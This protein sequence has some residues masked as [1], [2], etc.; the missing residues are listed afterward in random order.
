MTGDDED[1]DYEMAPDYDEDDVRLYP[2][3]AHRWVK[4]AKTFP[5]HFFL[6]QT[7]DERLEL[8]REYAGAMQNLTD[9]QKVDF[10]L[11]KAAK[12]LQGRG[13]GPTAVLTRDR[14]WGISLAQRCD[15]EGVRV[16]HDRALM[17]EYL[18]PQ[19]RSKDIC[20]ILFP[21]S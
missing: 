18:D 21:E 4:S 20:Q 16:L 14:R 6:E 11:A 15:R 17:L 9:R 7:V 5:K 12:Q 3:R 13:H 2:S 10:L 19:N 8:E 1:T